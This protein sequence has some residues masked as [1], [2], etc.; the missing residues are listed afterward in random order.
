V[1]GERTLRGAGARPVAL[2]GGSFLGQPVS[3]GEAMTDTAGRL[4]VLA[5]K[6]A[7]YRHGQASLTSLAV[8]AARRRL[9]VGD[10]ERGALNVYHADLAL[11][12]VSRQV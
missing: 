4:V 5:G 3:L 9:G 10:V 2:D 6:G 8:I 11:A 7:A 12:T 1:P